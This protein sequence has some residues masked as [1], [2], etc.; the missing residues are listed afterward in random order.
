MGA[1]SISLGYGRVCESVVIFRN[2]FQVDL[3]YIDVRTVGINEI[4]MSE[5]V[6]SF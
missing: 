4:R 2:E 1:A 5:F 3:F 6:I